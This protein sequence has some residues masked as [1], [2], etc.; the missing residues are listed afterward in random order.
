MVRLLIARRHLIVQRLRERQGPQRALPEEFMSR[1]WWSS[2]N[3]VNKRNNPPDHLFGTPLTPCYLHLLCP[4]TTSDY[5]LPTSESKPLEGIRSTYELVLAD[6]KSISQN[7]IVNLI[8]SPSNGKISP[9]SYKQ[10]TSRSF[11]VMQVHLPMIS[12][13]R[14]FQQLTCCKCR[15]QSC[16]PRY[17]QSTGTAPCR[18]RG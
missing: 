3:L 17:P 16:C 9:C 15:W 13:K 5:S 1:F 18:L 12:Q 11:S 10:H 2:S 8:L 6:P 4:A 7:H 14:C